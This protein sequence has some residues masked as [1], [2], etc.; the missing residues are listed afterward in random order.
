MVHA[1]KFKMFCELRAD[2]IRYEDVARVKIF[3]ENL[4][5]AIVVCR[6][7]KSLGHSNDLHADAENTYASDKH[8]VMWL[9]D[10]KRLSGLNGPSGSVSPFEPPIDIRQQ[11]KSPTELLD[12]AYRCGSLHVIKAA[13]KKGLPHPYYLGASRQE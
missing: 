3:E 5:R 2:S 12:K 4:G 6:M 9:I 8:R 11:K 7:E 1:A 13:P 10:T